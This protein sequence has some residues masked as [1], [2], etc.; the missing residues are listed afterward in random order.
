MNCKWGRGGLIGGSGTGALNTNLDRGIDRE[1]V[2]D[3]AWQVLTD[4]DVRLELVAVR[5]YEG[6]TSLGSKPEGNRG[7]RNGLTRNGAGTFIWR[8][9]PLRLLVAVVRHCCETF[10][11]RRIRSFVVGAAR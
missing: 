6:D 9:L 3:L 7:P 4:I 10:G 5:Y 8:P 11:R 1:S 2:T